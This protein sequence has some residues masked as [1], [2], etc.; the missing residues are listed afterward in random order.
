MNG[1]DSKKITF[2]GKQAQDAFT[3]KGKRIRARAVDIEPTHLEQMV[4]VEEDSSSIHSAIDAKVKGYK[5]QDVRRSILNI[6]TLVT[7]E[8]V[9]S[10]LHESRLLCHYCE[11]DVKVLF[12]TVR[13]PK[14]WTLDRIDNDSGHSSTNTVISCLRCNLKRRRLDKETFEATRNIVVREDNSENIQD[15]SSGDD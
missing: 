8:Q 14:Q 11:C 2:K 12:R 15:E 10:K 5:Q 13:D 3:P 1:N 4:L 9:I 7:R 6:E